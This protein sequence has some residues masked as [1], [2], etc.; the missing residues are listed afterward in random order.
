MYHCYI[1]I[2]GSTFTDP[3]VSSATLRGISGPGQLYIRKEGGSGNVTYTK[4]SFIS[5][6]YCQI[7]IF[8]YYID[9]ITGTGNTGFMMYHSNYIYFH[10]SCSLEYQ[11]NNSAGWGYQSGMSAYYTRQI[12]ILMDITLTSSAA[13]WLGGALV[14]NGCTSV[15]IYGD[16]TKSGAQ[17]TPHGVAAINEALIIVL[18]RL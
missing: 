14:F 4:S 1:E 11:G 10:S 12:M 18:I 16:L 13:G 5:I 17:F 2:Q 6:E 7:Q 9:F 15:G 3:T 8:F